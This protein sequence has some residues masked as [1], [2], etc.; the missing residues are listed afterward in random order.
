ML[1]HFVDIHIYYGQWGDP[2]PNAVPIDTKKETWLFP[3]FA[4]PGRDNLY[5]IG[6]LCPTRTI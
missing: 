6:G 4:Y 5:Y 1:L 2:S 3:I